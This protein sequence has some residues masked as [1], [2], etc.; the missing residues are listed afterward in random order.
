MLESLK[1]AENFEKIYSVF[2]Y[3]IFFFLIFF[4]VDA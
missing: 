2:N 4:Q 3:N 1:V